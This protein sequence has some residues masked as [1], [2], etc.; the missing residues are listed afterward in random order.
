ML[1]VFILSFY[2]DRTDLAPDFDSMWQYFKGN[3][4]LP[5]CGIKPLLG[6]H[7]NGGFIPKW[8]EPEL[9]DHIRIRPLFC[10]FYSGRLS[11]PPCAF[12]SAIVTTAPSPKTY[13]LKASVSL[14][15]DF[16]RGFQ[17]GKAAAAACSMMF[18]ILERVIRFWR[19][20]K[21]RSKMPGL[22]SKLKIVWFSILMA[23]L[24]MVC[25]HLLDLLR[26]ANRVEPNRSP[27]T[28]GQLISGMLW[29]PVIV[30]Y[31]YNIICTCYPFDSAV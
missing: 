13:C 12:C 26:L 28:Y 30:R 10:P 7:V 23:L 16:K 24:V 14:S 22:F 31:V 19:I 8:V 9:R 2:I 17:F 29:V 20:I 11:E 15:T 27:W 3:A 25:L 5:I 1:L 18:L 4:A 21:G 6:G